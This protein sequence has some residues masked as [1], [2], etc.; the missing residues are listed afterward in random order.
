MDC[1]DYKNREK[2]KKNGIVRDIFLFILPPAV[3]LGM[4]NKKRVLS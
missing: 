3:E 1:I 4:K 2:K